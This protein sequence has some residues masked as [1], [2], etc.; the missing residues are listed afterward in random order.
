MAA[1]VLLERNV[2]GANLLSQLT[3]DILTQTDWARPNSGSFPTLFKA[4][5]TRG[6]QMCIDLNTTAADLNKMS[7]TAYRTHDGTTGVDPALTY[8]RYKRTTGGA[9]ATNTYHYVLSLSKEHFFLS[10][11]GPRVGETGADA[12]AYGS[13]R[14]YVFLCDM[15][16][17]N[18]G[19]TVPTVLLGGP[20]TNVAPTLAALCHEVRASRNAADNAAWVPG[21]LCSLQWP[22][23]MPSGV[24][25]EQR[26]TSMDSNKLHMPPYVYYDNTEGERGRMYEL[27]LLGHTNPDFYEA[28]PPAVGS[29]FTYNSK[30]Y[31]IHQ[32][33]KSDSVEAAWGP[34]GGAANGSTTSPNNSFVVALPAA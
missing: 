24:L 32:L 31:K 9:F 22:N 16:P 29:T 34:L 23:G 8:I 1:P 10:V 6:A 17:Y 12:A 15:V 7:L 4:T 20:P 18:A 28:P 19:D 30:T 5:T 26:V 11:E 27:Y 14:N 21:H 25:N 33:N 2:L 13:L 3:T